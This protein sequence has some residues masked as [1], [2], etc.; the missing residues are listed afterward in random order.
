MAGFQINSALLARRNSQPQRSYLWR[1]EL[2]DITLANSDSNFP[3]DRATFF[4]NYSIDVPP[5]GDIN[6]RIRSVSTPFFQTDTDKEIVGSSSWNYAKKFE[7][8]AIN[9]DVLEYEDGNTLNYLKAWTALQT[10]PD[11]P[12]RGP[13]VG[14]GPQVGTTN[15]PAY[16]KF[17]VRFIRINTIKMDTYVDTYEGCFISS[18][19]ELSNDYEN[20]GLV[21][22]SISLTVDNIKDRAYYQDTSD[23][24]TLTM[25]KQKVDIQQKFGYN[26]TA[27]SLR[28]LIPGVAGQLGI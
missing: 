24:D 26:L 9:V 10:K 18:I 4:S 14:A 19:S 21:A 12:K 22:Y 27:D 16:Y 28:A 2:P 15:P 25:L 11:A 6:N 23:A 3:I 20:S 8:G 1:L 7:V 13:D 17:P 5:A